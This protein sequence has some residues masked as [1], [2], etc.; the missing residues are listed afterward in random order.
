MQVTVIKVVAMHISTL[1]VGELQLM[2]RLI[3]KNKQNK[4]AKLFFHF[5]KLKLKH[6][7]TYRSLYCGNGSGLIKL[8][9]QVATRKG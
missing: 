4:S 1:S 6:Q 2:S 5:L 7:N 9:W 8:T 3:V